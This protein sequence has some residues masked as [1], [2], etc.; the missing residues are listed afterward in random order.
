MSKQITVIKAAVVPQPKG[1]SVTEVS[2]KTDDGK[3]KGIKIFPFK[4]QAAVAKAFEG[5]QSGDVFDVEF[6][7]NDKGFWQFRSAAKTGKTEVTEA[8]VGQKATTSGATA[9]GGSNWE[10]SEERAARQVMIV[11]QSSLSTAVAYLTSVEPKGS[12]RSPND[13]IDVARIFETYVLQKDVE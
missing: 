6:E 7:Q 11:R 12:T 13:V 5:A 3:T 1:Y 9:K 2:Y 8:V 10:T 4:E